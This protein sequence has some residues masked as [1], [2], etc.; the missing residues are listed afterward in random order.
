MCRNETTAA[1]WYA[2]RLVP[3]TRELCVVVYER[4]CRRTGCLEQ[5][6]GFARYYDGK[7]HFTKRIP[8]QA[9]GVCWRPVKYMDAEEID[10]SNP[11][12]VL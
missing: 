4:Y 11:L 9:A 1:N 6:R 7:W 8:K 10:F 5:E 12:A 2:M 3:S